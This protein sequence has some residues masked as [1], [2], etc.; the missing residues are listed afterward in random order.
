MYIYILYIYTYNTKLIGERQFK[1]YHNPI[2]YIQWIKVYLK[3]PFVLQLVVYLLLSNTRYSVDH[4]ERATYHY[5]YMMK[6]T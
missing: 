6:K 3:W 1:K 2:E 4:I 5:I